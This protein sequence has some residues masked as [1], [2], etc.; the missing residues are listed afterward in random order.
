MQTY[1]IHIKGLV[2]GVGFRPHVY[3]LALRHG[4]SGWVCNAM[5]G[6]HI[7]F[8]AKSLAA[9]AFFQDI[10]NLAPQNAMI[11][12]SDMKSIQPK[13]FSSFQIVESEDDKEPDL[14]LTPDIALCDDCRK[15]M[16]TASGRRHQYPFTTCLNCGPRFS[17]IKQLPYDRHTTTMQPFTMCEDC[18]QEFIDVN[19]RRNHSQTNSCTDCAVKMH[20]FTSKEK[21][22]LYSEADKIAHVV[23]FLKEGKIVA[24]KG[25]GGYLLLCDATSEKAI[26]TLRERKQ[27][28]SKPFAVMYPSIEMADKDVVLTDGERLALQSNAAP[29]V[30][31]ILRKQTASSIC[32]QLI[33]PGLDKLGVMLSYT[34]L[35]FLLANAFNK[36]LI[37]TSA[38][39]SGSPVIYKDAV[40]LDN[41]F[42]VADYILTN[43]REIVMPQDD[44]VVQ[45]AGRQQQIVLRRSRGMAP[46]YFPNPFY[47]DND[48]VLAMGAELKSAFALAC[49]EHI[50]ISQYLGDQAN[51]EA[52]ESYGQTLQ[53][54][55]DLLKISPTVIT[56]DKH[57]GYSVSQYGKKI[58]GLLNIN[59]VISVQH[60][61]AHFAAVLAE[62]KLLQLN[63]K[64]LGFI[65]DGT[66][67]GDDGNIWGSELFLFEEQQIKRIAGLQYF[68]Q[69]LGDKMSKEPRLSALSL[70][71]T[72]PESRY[73][74]QPYFSEL[75]WN[76]YQ[77]ILEKGTGIFTS[78]M[79]RFLDALACI[80]GVTAFNSYE[81]EATMR[82]EALARNA[83]Y[84]PLQHYPLPLHNMELDWH[85]FVKEFLHDVKSGKDAG[86]IAWKIFYSL[87]VAVLDISNQQKI[88]KLAFSGGVF[89]N[90]LLVEIIQNLFSSSHELFFHKQVSPNDECIGLGQIAYYK[91]MQQQYISERKEHYSSL[92]QL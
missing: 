14:L 24:V 89:Q 87:A 77:K 66:G 8:N 2:Q 23:Q 50:Y 16:Q 20:L 1:H 51:L 49:Y 82:L 53:H 83:I 37:A 91:L 43:E 46:N 86:M 57:P 48:F 61:K 30:L 29:V 31:C 54:F 78:S 36:P 4:V 90:A 42:D 3:R 21:E 15:D 17:I 71:E 69:L 22:L 47:I 88:T 33:A 35:F 32:T 72:F 58:A 5:D 74:L 7:E 65:W 67:Y 81:G 68:T 41:L 85:F 75:E 10:I 55:L 73:L 38:N 28:P 62:N 9:K 44:S 25:I 56:I 92:H 76:Y 13:S 63:D 11:T 40:A 60:H 45:F 64:V 6:V 79:G 12:H 26:N 19:D 18:K 39:I 70:L 59:T 27:R 52:Q 84:K 80:I 34:P